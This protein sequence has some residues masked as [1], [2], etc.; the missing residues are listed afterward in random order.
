MTLLTG[1]LFL[2]GFGLEFIAVHV[3]LSDV[4]LVPLM[5]H[6]LSTLLI[7]T[8]YQLYLKPYFQQRSVHFYLF[9][10]C[11]C[12]FIPLFGEMISA[13]IVES[14]YRRHAHAHQHA[15]LFDETINLTE[16]KPSHSTYGAGGVTLRLLKQEEVPSERIKAL[17]TL[18][19]TQLSSINQ[20]VSQLLPDTSDE[21]RLLAFNI[22]D[23]QESIITKRINQ[24]FSMLETTASNH[25]AYAN[26]EKN[27]A[28]LH[29]ELIYNHLI[30]PEL[31]E[32]I[33]NKAESYALSA[34][35]IL[36]DDVSTFILLGKIYT[37]SKQYEKAE[38]IL[39]QIVFSEVCPAQLLP[40]LAEIKF[41]MHDYAAVQH[42][43]NASDTLLD[44]APIA[45]VRR[46][47]NKT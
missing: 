26:I 3:F 16:I 44:I 22:L 36:K 38:K 33:L 5:T 45:S 32:S 30:A 4:V 40:Y 21:M 19:Q 31:E 24:L 15:E 37:H 13:L 29:W 35:N 8:S 43:L 17:L 2:F 46:F 18:N 12:F 1:L 28:M 42:Y 39:N 20:L 34:M 10:F 11:L 27:L 47:W 7:I 25:D 14:L 9:L 6:V 41:K 23:E